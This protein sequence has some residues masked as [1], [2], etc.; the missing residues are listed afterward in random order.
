MTPFKALRPSLFASEHDEPSK[1]IHLFDSV[2]EDDDDD[3]QMDTT[4]S[5]PRVSHNARG[6]PTEQLFADD[7][8][9]SSSTAM[10]TRST[11]R[12]RRK[13]RARLSTT[14]SS[15][16]GSMVSEIS[17]QDSTVL[18]HMDLNASPPVRRKRPS[19]S[20]PAGREELMEESDD[21][22]FL[23]PRVSPSYR[24]LDGRTVTSKNP[25]SP[26]T[27]N[28]EEDAY[29]NT[30]AA[31]TFPVALHGTHSFDSTDSK[32]SGSNG[33]HSVPTIR[34][35]VQLLR[36]QEHAEGYPDPHGRYSFTGSPIEEIDILEHTND[37]MGSKMRRLGLDDNACSS[38]FVSA[39]LKSREDTDEISPTDVSNFPDVFHFEEKE[40]KNLV[41]PPTPRKA[42]RPARYT[43]TRNATPHTPMVERRTVARRP[44]EEQEQDEDTLSTTQSRFYQDFDIIGQLG[45]GSFG[46]VYK[47]LS[48]VD[49]CMYA[50]KAA[51]RKAKGIADRD[52]M[53]KEVRTKSV[54]TVIMFC[55]H[56][57]THSMLL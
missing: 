20:H 26:Y 43:P 19:D 2:P 24:T 4:V 47:C 52:R 18:R 27:P 54:L 41:A 37:S 16:D 51:R 10:S 22:M 35:K 32:N 1:P 23:S 25:F 45:T 12:K 14:T 34:P 7:E 44:R 55:A 53:L 49:G 6:L 42:Q 8:T 31:P 5:P 13:Q 29:M 40:D 57:L 46:T 3:E 56:V 48:K 50:V 15:P 38:L 11:C 36:R 30:Q 17:D 9:K 33:Q 21:D 39:H 28:N